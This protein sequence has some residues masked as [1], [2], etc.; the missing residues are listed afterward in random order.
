MMENK[1]FC[2]GLNKTG[3]SSLHEAF[4]I[5][6]I[7]SIH[8][9]DE[10]GKNLKSIFIENY[11]SNRD[12][13]F[14]LDDYEAFSDWDRPPYTFEIIKKFD[15]HYPNSKFIVNIRDVNDWLDSR[16][17]HVRRNQ[18][19]KKKYPTRN[20]TWLDI[21]RKA[22]KKEYEFHYQSIETYFKNRKKDILYFDVTKGD[23]WKELCP[24]LNQ[25]IPSSCFPSENMQFSL[26]NLFKKTLNKLRKL[27]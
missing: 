27:N 24:F 25:P 8:Y 13:L 5:L 1:I 19:L 26:K 10:K 3:T 14:G 18:L 11:L 2:I 20:I 17:N 7:K 6:G 4:Q 23:S 21:D 15:A 9:E 16:E 22:W 12:I